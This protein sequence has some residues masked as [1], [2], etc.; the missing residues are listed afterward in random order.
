MRY[1]K[2][3][4]Y[5]FHVWFRDTHCALFFLHVPT[6]AYLPSKNLCNCLQSYLFNFILVRYTK[7]FL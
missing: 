7:A 2:R 3:L 4:V 5:N 1:F 6:Y